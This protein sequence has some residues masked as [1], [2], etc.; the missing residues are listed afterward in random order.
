[1][2]PVVSL[3]IRE[4]Q[5]LPDCKKRWADVEDTGTPSPWTEYPLSDSKPFWPDTPTPMDAF[6]DPRVSIKNPVLMELTEN[7][8]PSNGQTMQTTAAPYPILA[9]T[10]PAL[11]EM[12]VP[13]TAA[14][15]IEAPYV[16]LAQTLPALSEVAVSCLAGPVAVTMQQGFPGPDFDATHHNVN[17][18]VLMIA[19][20]PWGDNF[21]DGNGAMGIQWPSFSLPQHNAGLDSLQQAW[22]VDDLKM[23]GQTVGQSAA[24][25]DSLS[26]PQS[27]Q[28]VRHSSGQ[29]RP[30]AWFWR[31]QGCHNGDNCGYCHL[32]PEGELK[33][34]KK[35]KIA[36][37][38]MGALTPVKPSSQTAGGWGLKLDSLIQDTP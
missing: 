34:R 19:A 18:S 11:S 25:V 29:C 16:V 3:P 10:S 38:R 37:M 7:V 12:L 20:Q 21:H 28:E 6:C 24:A 33:S 17:E 26:K 5:N 32:C 8:P 13:C 9:Q 30:C 31:T 1:M 2:A 23:S 4:M 15:P 14:G 27:R 22:Q 36:A 35:T